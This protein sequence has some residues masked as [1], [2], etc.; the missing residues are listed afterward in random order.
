MIPRPAQYLL[1]FDDLCPTI[2]QRRWQ[3][4]LVLVNDYQI[5]PILAVVPDN[6]D[7]GLK[8]EPDDPRF[9]DKMREMEAAGAA[10][11]LHG[12]RH[13]CKSV[14]ASLL[15][16]HTRSEFAGFDYETQRL[17]IRKGIE[18]LR[19]KGLNPRL[20]VAPRHGFDRITLRALRAEGIEYI[21][22]GFARLPFRRHGVTWVPQQLWSPLRKSA[23][24]WTICMHP[25]ATRHSEVE[26]LRDFLEDHSR[27]FTSFD[28]V[29]NEFQPGELDLTERLYQRLALWRV[30]RRNRRARRRRQERK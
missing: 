4:L 15:R 18:I 5:R 11:A 9:W 6:H 16:L 21:S 28:R 1:R 30:Q 12:Y 10:I 13:L 7:P 20:W 24:L 22:D 2:S 3:Q 19:E 8:C 17:W 27:Q 14:G 25:A 23:G 26:R 29:A